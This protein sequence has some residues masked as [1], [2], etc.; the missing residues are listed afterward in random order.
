MIALLPKLLGGHGLASWLQHCFWCA[1]STCR[2][3]SLTDRDVSDL[4]ATEPALLCWSGDRSTVDDVPEAGAYQSRE[5]CADAGLYSLVMLQHTDDILD[6]SLLI[7]SWK[8]C[9]RQN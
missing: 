9:R 3:H 7:D 1:E 8:Q 6:G 2:P 5:T 4:I